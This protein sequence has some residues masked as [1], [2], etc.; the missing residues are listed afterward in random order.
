MVLNFVYG[1]ARL[2]TD[3]GCDRVRNPKG[4][5][6]DPTYLMVTTGV[7]TLSLSVHMFI[8]TTLYYSSLL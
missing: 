8:N 3:H 1:Q 2:W 6:S 7:V 4:A 5:T